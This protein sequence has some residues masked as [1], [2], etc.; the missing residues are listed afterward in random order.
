MQGGIGVAKMLLA[1]KADANARDNEGYTPLR[2]AAAI[3]RKDMVDFLMVK[4]TGVHSRERPNSPEVD[5][6]GFGLDKGPLELACEGDRPAMVLVVE[7]NVKTFQFPLKHSTRSFLMPS[8]VCSG[9]WGV[10]G[11]GLGYGYNASASIGRIGM[12]SAQ[13]HFSW[14]WTVP[15]GSRGWF[16]RDLTFP[17]FHPSEFS[18]QNRIKIK[19]YPQ[20]PKKLC[21]M[22]APES[23]VGPRS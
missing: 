9:G 20:R 4:K 17:L 13:F 21:P 14:N 18:F 10:S 23:S 16:D 19:S 2:L 15:D 7:T 11:D 5:M 1:N 3:G 22:G 6:E 12:D 8:P